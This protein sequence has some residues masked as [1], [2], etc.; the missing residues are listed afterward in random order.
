MYSRLAALAVCAWVLTSTAGLSDTVTL[1]PKIFPFKPFTL[2]T[3]ATFDGRSI[4][5][6]DLGTPTVKQVVR[7]DANHAIAQRVRINTDLNGLTLGSDGSGTIYAAD[8]KTTIWRIS[9]ATGAVTKIPG[10]GIENCSQ[11]N[12]AAGGSFVWVLNSCE[13]KN[14]SSSSTYS[15]LLL[16]IDPRT[17][18]R[19]VAVLAAAG[20]AGNRLLINQGKIWVSGDYCSVV[21]LNTLASTTFRP[22]GTAWVGHISANADKVYLTAQG[23][24]VA[25]QFVIAVDPN[26]LKETAR[27]SLDEG[28][29]NLIADNQHVIAFGQKIYVLSARDLTLERVIIP[30]PTLVQ[31][32]PD[33]VRLH[34]GDLL[35]ADGELGVDIPNRILLFQNWRPSAAP[36]PATK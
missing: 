14:D 15:P 35:I 16:R 25:T 22:D 2:I 5:L 1:Q 11:S 17:G 30:S 4:W 29:E 21:D 20:N 28:V 33:W 18:S 19:N 9:S 24:N 3:G 10:L 27:V 12:I 32:H 31:Y 7:L 8:P 36:T 6:A 23:P 13:V 34:N 26:T